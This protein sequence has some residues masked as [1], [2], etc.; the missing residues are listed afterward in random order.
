MKSFGARST[1]R[2]R[3]GGMNIRGWVYSGEFLGTLD[4]SGLR[5]GL[6]LQGCPLTAGIFR[7]LPHGR[8]KEGLPVIIGM[9]LTRF[10]AA[11][12]VS[13]TVE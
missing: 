11:E 1:I 4:G 7:I 8:Q 9:R 2:F 6:F 5:Y 13:E 3:E 12:H 10:F